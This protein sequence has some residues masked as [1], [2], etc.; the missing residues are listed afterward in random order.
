LEKNA[1][2]DKNL[3]RRII[4]DSMSYHGWFETT[5]ATRTSFKKFGLP[6]EAS[7]LAPLFYDQCLKLRKMINVN[8]EVHVK[9]YK[10]A[11]QDASI[12]LLYEYP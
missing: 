3:C 1:D 12:A 6:L 9:R 5:S 2:G 7:A 10:A 4:Y 11:M 8:V